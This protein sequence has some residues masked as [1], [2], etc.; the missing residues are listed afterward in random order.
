MVENAK[1]QEGV[2]GWTIRNAYHFKHKS[3][4]FAFIS[5]NNVP[6]SKSF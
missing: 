4:C 2:W 1:K 5:L 6:T 3:T